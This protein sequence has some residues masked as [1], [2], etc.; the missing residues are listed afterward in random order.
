[1]IVSITI[2]VFIQKCI[3]SEWFKADGDLVNIAR[4][5]YFDGFA[6][7]ADQGGE[8]LEPT[9]AGNREFVFFEDKF[10]V[11]VN[12]NNGVDLRESIIANVSRPFGLV[13]QIKIFYILL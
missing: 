11:S 5:I 10:G 4:D 2:E 3:Q 12:G 13:K 6:V 9:V 8:H 1:M 7:I